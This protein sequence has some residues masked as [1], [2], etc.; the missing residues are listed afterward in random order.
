MTGREHIGTIE[1]VE[2]L[3]TGAQSVQLQEIDQFTT[4]HVKHIADD[5]WISAKEHEVKAQRWRSEVERCVGNL[6]EAER[7]LTGAQYASPQKIQAN[8]NEYAKLIVDLVKRV[9]QK[10]SEILSLRE[11]VK[12]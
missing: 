4:G 8:S 9:E 5:G 7:L 3:S 12:R 6:E 2:K 10:D 1:S 11:E